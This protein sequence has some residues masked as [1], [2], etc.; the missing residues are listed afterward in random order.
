MVYHNH[1]YWLTNFP[2]AINAQF[3]ISTLTTSIHSPACTMI[4]RSVVLPEKLR[5][6][7]PNMWRLHT[8]IRAG[9]GGT[10]EPV[11]D[12]REGEFLGR[13]DDAMDGIPF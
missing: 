8:L 13:D 12:C 10:L 2:I 9:R 6:W 4:L 3:T 11:G 7:F 1:T 5:D